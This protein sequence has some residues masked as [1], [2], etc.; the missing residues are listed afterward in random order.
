MTP[1]EPITIALSADEG[2]QPLAHLVRSLVGSDSADALWAHGG[3]WL[4]G[5][6]VLDTALPTPAVGTLVLHTPPGGCYASIAITADDI[7]YEDAWLLALNKRAGWYSSPTPWDMH[8]HVLTALSH[9]L[10]QRDGTVP[11]LHLAHQLDRDTTGV[12]LCSKTP[13]ANAP[14]QEAFASRTIQKT[15]QCVCHGE[16]ADDTFEQYTGHGRKKGRWG[17]YPLEQLGMMLP[18]GKPVR[19][20]HTSFRVERRLGTAA[21][22]DAVPHTGRTHQI[23]L[24][25]EATGYPI[26]GDTRYGGP[27][28]YHGQPVPYHML[29]AARLCLHHPITGAWIELEAP[30]PAHMAVVTS[31]LD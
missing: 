22:L 15:Y 24:H 17:I 16:P 21:L 5:R 23:R 19:L 28:H 12:L 31:G 10:Q 2:G 25:L 6:R 7:C 26:V 20:A 29:H 4:D 30:L 14:L 8:A 18:N 13:Y 9:F 3:V 1:S 27:S 11:P